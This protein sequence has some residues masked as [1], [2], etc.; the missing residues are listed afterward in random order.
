MK[1]KL[2]FIVFLLFSLP[3]YIFSQDFDQKFGKNRVQFHKDFEDWSEYKTQNFT[4]YWYGKS[5]HVGRVAVQLAEYDFLEIKNLFGYPI[6]DK[7]EIIV[8]SDLTDIK[9]SNIGNEEAFE[10]YG[11][12]TKVVDTKIFVYFDG[13]HRHLRKQIREG[14]AGVFLKSMDI[15]SNIQEM[16]QQAISGDLPPWFDLGLIAY[17]GEEWNTASDNKLKGLILSKRFKNFNRLADD[18]PRLTGNSFWHFIKQKYGAAA[19]QNLLHIAR[20]YGSLDDGFLLTIGATYEDIIDSW[21]KHYIKRYTTD[22]E[23]DFD[24]IENNIISLKKQKRL[25][26]VSHFKINPRGD[27]LAYVTNDLGKAKVWVRDL[28]TGKT[29]KVFKYG[30]RNGIQRTDYNYP[31]IAWRPNG[32]ELAVLYERRDVVK[33]QVINIISMEVEKQDFGPQFQ[34]VLSMDYI[35]NTRMVIS[36]IVNGYSDI[37]V[38]NTQLNTSNRLTHDFY[39][40]LDAAFVNI[41]GQK[42]ILFASNRTDSILTI[43][44]M[45]TILP[46]DNFD[47]YYVNLEDQSTLK[48]LIKVTNTPHV[49]ERQPC[50]VDTT[51]FSYLSDKAGITNEEMG[52]LVDY[53]HHYENVIL[54]KDG[55]KITIHVDS[56]LQKLDSALIDTIYRQPVIKTKAITYTNSNLPSNLLQHHTASFTGKMVGQVLWNNQERLFIK[57]N[58]PI[59]V[60]K[61]D[62]TIFKKE[63]LK[64]QE[65]HPYKNKEDNVRLL[66]K[67]KNADSEQQLNDQQ[68]FKTQPKDYYFQ[69]KFAEKEN[70]KDLENK[71]VT[72]EQEDSAFLTNNSYY[73]LDEPIFEKSE[74]KV[75]KFKSERIIPY[76]LK[77]R[78]DFFTLH[79][80]NAAVFDGI[81]SY[82]DA[83]GSKHNPNA[84]GMLF[85]FNFKDIFEDYIIE[86]GIKFPVAFNGSEIYLFFDDNKRMIDKR[87]GVYR[88]KTTNLEAGLISIFPYKKIDIT[89]IGV[90]RLKY[91]FDIFRSVR[92]TATFRMDRSTY[93][94]TDIVTL[95]KPT[96]TSQRLGLK[97]AYV[98][99]NTLNV[100]LNIKN[101]SRYRFFAEA[102]KRFNLSLT[103]D[104]DLQ[105]KKGLMGIVGFDARHYQRLL[106]YSVI[107]LRAAG[108]TSFGSEKI[109]FLS[110]GTSGWMLPKYNNNISFP[111]SDDFAYQI[112]EPNLR[113]FSYNI[114]NGNTYALLNTEVR[115]PTLRYVFPR[116]HSNF[117]KNFQLVGFFDMGTA[118]H[119]KSPY[120]DE[121]PLNALTVSGKKVTVNV[122]YFRDPVVFGYGAGVRIPV[123]GHLLRVDY[124]WGV[125]SK[126][127]QK[128][129]LF[130][131]LGMDF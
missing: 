82:T 1:T 88:K 110:G 94:A 101:G 49:S 72:I 71:E 21:E 51:Y 69:S 6:N 3:S 55:T 116:S 44:K 35:D 58:N 113:G 38:Y 11:E 125:E 32:T 48:E 36:A 129:R 5:R 14:I 2:I 54:L 64:L 50:A 120:G 107:A 60:A 128:P 56:S 73:Y 124:A 90:Y 33:L 87:I 95:E 37:F 65:N 108:A 79:L 100:A 131:S 7:I 68:L 92:A 117:V 103:G 111:Q 22:K 89:H 86:T 102:G 81:E 74:K 43:Q 106:K 27:K 112:T 67:V 91:P 18:Y 8:Y 12:N 93:A 45:D 70:E 96:K 9:Q 23:H 85:K 39:D 66:K 25:P 98:F 97:V 77:F 114:R 83:I 28:T 13:N 31:M 63:Q 76:R 99:D 78:G 127:V 84:S 122:R 80:D 75:I 40:D 17:A 61:P 10:N 109:L 62:L 47:I 118:W 29:V 130:V 119:G 115:I 16:V 52:Y 123:L 4:V 41:H 126:E 34:R 42:G 30:F 20:I 121:N 19:I 59:R 15:G 24:E 46:I 26:T 57:D 105:F 104:P 53:I